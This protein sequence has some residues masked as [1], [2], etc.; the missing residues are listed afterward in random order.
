MKKTYK[1]ELHLH[2]SE[3]SKCSH[4]L[5]KEA[6]DFYISKGYS[7]MFVTDHF[8]GSTTVP[9][10]TPWRERIDMF[11]GG[12]R[13][14][15][16]YAHGKEF[17]VFRGLE[18]SYKGNDFL[19]YGLS[20]DWLK[21]NEFISWQLPKILDEVRAAGAFVIHAHPFA[22]APWIETVRLLPHK[23][24]AVEV[25]NGKTPDEFNARAKWYAQ[26]YGLPETAGSDAHG[27]DLKRL[28]GIA[29]TRKAET[30]DDI[31][32]AIRSRNAQIIYG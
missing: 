18:Y 6:V 30:A 21:E 16:E 23:V 27:T 7:G 22:E 10:G 28:T 31:I 19:F 4:M 8:T 25:L 15:E 29:L 32:S 14:A 1:Y 26:S 9:Q 13:A 17:K 5:A 20:I 3:G 12:F 11:F 2:T 24:D